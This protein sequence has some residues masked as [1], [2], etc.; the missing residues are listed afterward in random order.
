LCFLIDLVA[1][2]AVG[3]LLAVT[4]LSTHRISKFPSAD[5]VAGLVF[6]LA[7]AATGGLIGAMCDRW[8]GPTHA[9]NSPS[10]G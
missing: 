3:C 5:V 1:A 10:K 6:T 8:I 7:V 2:G 4:F 9:P